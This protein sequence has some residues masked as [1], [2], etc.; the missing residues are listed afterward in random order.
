VGGGGGY[1]GRAAEI[2]QGFQIL[3]R[4][5]TD[6]PPAGTNLGLPEL[7]L[8]I[9]PGF[10]GT[11]R[12]PRLVGLQQ[13]VQM[14]L[15]SKPIKEKAALKLG[16]VEGVVPAAQLLAAARALAL[17]IAAGTKPRNFSLYR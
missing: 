4:R 2:L 14:M 5:Q 12:L 11:Q 1:F 6:T 9:L 8:G 15:T 10:G 17:E 16:L 13:A 3:S 7:S